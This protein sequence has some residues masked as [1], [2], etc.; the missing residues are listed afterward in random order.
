MFK[1]WRD[2]GSL[3]THH[4]FFKMAYLHIINPNSSRICGKAFKE[5]EFNLK[6]V[7]SR[8]YLPKLILNKVLESYSEWES[9]KEMISHSWPNISL[10]F[11]MKKE[12]VPT[13]TWMHPNPSSTPKFTKYRTPKA[14]QIV[15]EWSVTIKLLHQERRVLIYLNL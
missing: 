10:D 3:S 7:L 8:L 12:L 13:S 9:S 15:Q 1:S 11:L 14:S 5:S 4:F 6:R 2:Q